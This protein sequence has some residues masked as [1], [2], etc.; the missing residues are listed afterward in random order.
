MLEVAY[1]INHTDQMAI[2]VTRALQTTRGQNYYEISDARM[3]ANVE[4][5]K[6][7]NGLSIQISRFEQHQPLIVK[8]MGTQD[9]NLLVL[10][11]HLNGIAKLNVTDQRVDNDRHDGL[12]HGAYFASSSVQSYATFPSGSNNEQFHIIIDKNWMRRFFS[13]DIDPVL[14]KIEIATPFFMFERMNAK[15]TAL[16]LSVFK[17]DRKIK[18]RK[19]FLHGKTLEILSLFFQKLEQR[20]ENLGF[21]VSNYKDILRLFDLM[22]YY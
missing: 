11:F 10:D 6:L 22:T 18:F 16:L 17:S 9:P 1:Q 3:K 15:L 14:D 13:E 4:F 2:A 20:G 12:T 5:Y 21:G 8:R 19:S 7:T